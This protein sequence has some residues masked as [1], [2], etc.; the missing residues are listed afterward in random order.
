MIARPR[1][2]LPLVAEDCGEVRVNVPSQPASRSRESGYAYLMVMFLVLMMVIG[3][4]VALQ[5]IYTQGRRMREDDMIWRGNQYARAIRLYYRKTGHYPQSLD[6]LK[7]GLPQLTFLRYA[8]YKDPTNSAEEGAWRLIYVN[9]AGQII[10][11]VRYATLQQMAIMDLNG[12][13]IPTTATLGSIGTPVSSMASGSGSANG[14]TGAS[15]PNAPPTPSGGNASGQPPSDSTTDNS[16][17]GTQAPASGQTPS[18][19]QASSSDQPVNP[20]SLLKPTGPVDGPVLGAFLTGVGGGTKSD[21]ASIKVYNFGKKYKDWEFIWNPL[22]DQARAA[23]QALSG[24]GGQP[25]GAGQPGSPLGIGIPNPGGATGFGGT[26][27]PPPSQPQP[28]NQ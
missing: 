3:S 22:E 18:S 14:V 6:D 19:D 11:S 8:A 26:I 10:G 7:T 17:S 12:G 5:N 25:A 16:A 21:A 15:N 20:L 27:V 23:Q 4:Q 2:S 1:I 9:A 28:Q 24:A 13:K